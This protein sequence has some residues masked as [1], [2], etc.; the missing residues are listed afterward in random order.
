MRRCY[1][2]FSPNFFIKIYV[3][4][5]M[6]VQ[7]NLQQNFKSNLSIQRAPYIIRKC[8]DKILSPSFSLLYSLC[9]LEMFRNLVGVVSKQLKAV[10]FNFSTKKLNPEL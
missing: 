6:S 3:A 4:E 1:V 9:S 7:C 8:V 5:Q 10:I 2:P